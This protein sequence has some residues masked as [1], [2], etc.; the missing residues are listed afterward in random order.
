MQQHWTAVFNFLILNF[1]FIMRAIWVRCTQ[2]YFEKRTVST[3]GPQLKQ[4]LRSG[5]SGAS[6][7][8]EVNWPNMFEYKWDFI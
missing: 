6:W 1:K 2:K 4:D 3:E 7:N 8:W 5:R